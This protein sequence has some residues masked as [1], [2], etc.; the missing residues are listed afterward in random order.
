[1]RA[2]PLDD[3]PLEQRTEA[4][5]VRYWVD[6]TF[7]LR[8]A[9]ALLRKVEDT[10]EGDNLR[11]VGH[12][13]QAKR[14]HRQQMEEAASHGGSGPG[15]RDELLRT[16]RAVPMRWCD[17][18]DRLDAA[19]LVVTT[20]VENSARVGAQRQVAAPLARRAREREE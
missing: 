1:M 4:Q 11:R 3:H 13:C 7:E 17:E 10:V 16:A 12:R 15:G 9:A 19:R 14:R 6:D 8:H 20:L 18:K 5:G 2:A